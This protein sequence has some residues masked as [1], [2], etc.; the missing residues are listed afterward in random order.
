MCITHPWRLAAEPVSLA[1]ESNSESNG[2][3]FSTIYKS[4]YPGL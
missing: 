2:T 3:N 1:G 4:E